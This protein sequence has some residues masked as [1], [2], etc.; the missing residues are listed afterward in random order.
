MTKYV[1]LDENGKIEHAPKNKNGIINYNVNKA[2]L[3]MDG[4][5]ELV[6]IEKPVK[7]RKY[8]ITYT[9]TEEQI[10]EVLKYLESDA[11]YKIRKANEELQSEIDSYES[12]IKDLD[13]KRIR[14]ISEPEIKDELTGETWLDFYN[15][16][17]IAYRKQIQEL[18][19]RLVD[20]GIIN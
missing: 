18:K 11:E 10:T 9:E 6:E 8:S 5:K 19:K 4:Y 2:L 12:Y 20:N 3:K 17:I 14:A 15:S 7:S 1:K 13:F 16:Q